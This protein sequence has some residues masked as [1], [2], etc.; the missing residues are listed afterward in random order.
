VGFAA[1]H[2]MGVGGFRHKIPNPAATY[3]RGYTAS[4][5]VSYSHLFS[6]SSIKAIRL[7]LWCMNVN[8]CAG[9]CARTELR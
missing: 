6:L 8:N 7:I 9:T 5:E 3:C 1:V 4:E 2:Q